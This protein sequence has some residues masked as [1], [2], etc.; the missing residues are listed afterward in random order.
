MSTADEENYLHRHKWHIDKTQNI[1]KRKNKRQK[2]NRK[3]G[4]ND[5]KT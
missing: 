1:L 2:Y 5:K 3:G 4:N